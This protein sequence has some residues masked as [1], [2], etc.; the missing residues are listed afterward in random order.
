LG[1][2]KEAYPIIR[3]N[4]ALRT[5]GTWRIGCAPLRL[6]SA[7]TA[8]SCSRRRRSLKRVLT[9]SC[10]QTCT[11]NP[12]RRPAVDHVEGPVN[13]PIPRPLIGPRAARASL[14]RPAPSPSPGLQRQQAATGCPSEAAPASVG[15]ATNRSRRRRS[16]DRD[17]PALKRTTGRPGARVNVLGPLITPSPDFFPCY[18]PETS[19]GPQITMSFGGICFAEAHRGL[20]AR[21]WAIESQ[22]RPLRMTLH[23]PRH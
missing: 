9:P 21:F 13:P 16:H 4:G 1:A 2:V 23:A 10:R 15:A 19:V 12:T 5:T 14:H 18:P 22:P 11:G 8:T 17:Q 3:N 7:G 6:A 20:F